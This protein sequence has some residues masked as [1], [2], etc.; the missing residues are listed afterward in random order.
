M[1]EP[2]FLSDVLKDVAKK[3]PAENYILI[4]A[5]HANGWR[6]DDDGEYPEPNQKP[7][8]AMTD[9]NFNGRAITAKEL[10]S[11]I[12]QANINLSTVVFDC[13]FQNSIEYLSELT[14]IPG[15]KYTLGSG[16]STKGGDY[17]D[18]VAELFKAANGSQD[19]VK[20]LSNYAETYAERHKQI[21]LD[22]NDV[23]LMNVDF[24][25]V[26]L[27]KLKETWTPIKNMVDF[28]CSNYNAADSAKYV[29]P[30]RYCYQYYNWAPKYDLIDY[31]TQLQTKDAPYANNAQYTTLL[32][33]VTQAFKSSIL[34]HAYS[35]NYVDDA[36]KPKDQA[37]KFVTMS[38]NLGAKGRLQTDWDI[39]NDTHLCYDYEGKPWYI[40]ADG[41]TWT[42]ATGESVSLYYNWTYSYD[43]STFE[44]KT[45]WTRWLKLNP[46]MPCNNPP[47]GDEGD[48]SGNY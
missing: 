38:I 22:Y 24:A 47:F 16:H 18:L 4:I 44:A 28:L 10:A 43:K 26:D 37:D 35:L 25:V 32:N 39:E 12:R 34:H 23:V 14:D 48:T 41:N 29:T 7:A 8:A 33:A 2:G 1:Y 36:A 46:V 9:R 42:P 40:S 11:A 21:Y 45:G 31:L 15:L 5:G 17:S 13:C 27:A 6:V 30:T 3:C 20:A 19:L